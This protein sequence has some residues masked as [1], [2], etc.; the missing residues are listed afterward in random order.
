MTSQL[1]LQTAPI[2]I[3][4]ITSQIKWNQAIKFG[5]LIEHNKRKIFLQE[6]CGKWGSWLISDFLKIF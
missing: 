1:G 4:P 3:L 2:H 6:L 5:Q